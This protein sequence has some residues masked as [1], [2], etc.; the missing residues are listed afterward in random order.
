MGL[1]K[2][3]G[4]WRKI[5]VYMDDLEVCPFQETP[6]I[7]GATRLVD[8]PD[9][10]HH[11][12]VSCYRFEHNSPYVPVRHHSH[13]SPAFDKETYVF[14]SMFN[15]ISS[16]DPLNIGRS[17]NKIF[18]DGKADPLPLQNISIW[19]ICKKDLWEITQSPVWPQRFFIRQAKS[20]AE[21]FR[22]ELLQM[23]RGFHWPGRRVSSSSWGWVY[24]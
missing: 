16:D 3:N 4:L 14:L 1:P 9:W 17:P 24:P 5:L 8:Q 12:L 10:L 18:F 13:L 20:I 15:L 2:M 7:F 11:N 6:I 19:P 23:V 22:E 21:D